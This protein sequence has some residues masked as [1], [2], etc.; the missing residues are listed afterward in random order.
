MA[1]LLAAGLTAWCVNFAI[2]QTPSPALLVL[3]KEDRALAIVDP[4]NNTVSGRVP[5][6]DGPHEIT[7]SSDGKF[8]FVGNYGSREPGNTISVIDLNQR[9]EIRRVDLGSIRRPHGMFFA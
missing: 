8:A 6:G 9:K 4:S 1:R 7:V 2:A 5:V 3:N